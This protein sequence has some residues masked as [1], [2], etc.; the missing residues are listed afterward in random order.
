MSYPKLIADVNSI[1]RVFGT[2]TEDEYKRAYVEASF[3]A[4]NKETVRALVQAN[5]G[6]PHFVRF[7]LDV[8]VEEIEDKK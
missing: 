7:R 5:L 6:K 8:H 2:E 4:L 3:A 1:A